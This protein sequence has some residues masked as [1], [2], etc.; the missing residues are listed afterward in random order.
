MTMNKIPAQEPDQSTVRTYLDHLIQQRGATY[1]DLSRL[2]GRNPTYIHQFI[3]RGIPRKLD[4]EDRRKLATYFDVPQQKL[5]G[6]PTPAGQVFANKAGETQTTAVDFILP[7]TLLKNGQFLSPRLQAGSDLQ[8]QIVFQ[9]GWLRSVASQSPDAIAV[10]HIKED[11]M[12]PTLPIG[13]RVLVDTADRQ[14]RDG[15]VLLKFASLIL[16]RRIM[17]DPVSDSL[18]ICCDNPVYPS[19]QFLSPTPTIIIGRVVWAS[20]TL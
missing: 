1:A 9:L 20:I 8:D 17:A 18:K 13:T 19:G 2:L 12:A 14:P 16:V 7:Q 15:V 3:H 4:E 6:S 11:A 5:G 10:F